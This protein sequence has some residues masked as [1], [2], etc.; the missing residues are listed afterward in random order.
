MKYSGSEGENKGENGE[1]CGHR[2]NIK[3]INGYF[4]V[5]TDL[6]T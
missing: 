4:K 1:S 5:I 2:S 3:T 6:C